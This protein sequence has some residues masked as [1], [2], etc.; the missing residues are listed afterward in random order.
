[1]TRLQQTF[2]WPASDPDAVLQVVLGAL[3]DGGMVSLPTETG[4][5]VVIPAVF[6]EPL[7]SI[8]DNWETCALAMTSVAHVTNWIPNMSATIR[9][10]VARCLPGPVVLRIQGD[11]AAE[12]LGAL[13]PMFQA[14]VTQGNEVAVRL[15]AHEFAMQVLGAFDG[16]AMI[17]EASDR[18]LIDRIVDK[19]AVIV[20]DSA[21]T[22]QQ[23]PTIIR[24]NNAAWQVDRPGA[25]AAESLQLLAARWIV[26]VCTGNTCRS[27]MA[28]ALCKRALAER[29][30]CSVSDLLSRGFWVRS[31]G[32]AA[33]PGDSATPQAQTAVRALGA[34]LTGHV[35]RPLDPDTAALADDLIVMTRGHLRAIRERYP[36]LGAEPRLLCGEADLPDPVG[37]AQPV[38]DDCARV[39]WQHV[40]A[41]ATEGYLSCGSPLAATTADSR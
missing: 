8:I 16:D 17:A 6:S 33:W 20:R 22:F 4:A 3:R 14:R 31:A 9:R 35:S 41:L 40:Q 29:L 27:P 25:V 15:P 13:P 30:G 5:A 38:Y 37:A 10:L 32:L 24:L 2:D 26:F 21:R 28:E 19:M 1:M 23:P 36:E 34:D 39:I 7:A 11:S 12:R 18:S